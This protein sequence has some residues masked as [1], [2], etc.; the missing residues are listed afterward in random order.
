VVRIQKDKLALF[1]GPH[2]LGRTG[3]SQ[4]RLRV[5]CCTHTAHDLIA[6]QRDE[7]KP[8]PDATLDLPMHALNDGTGRSS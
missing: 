3:A 5:Q 6:Y 2:S 4:V 7:F 8:Y 1:S